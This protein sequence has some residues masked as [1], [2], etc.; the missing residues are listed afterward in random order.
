MNP[1]KNKVVAEIAIQ[2]PETYAMLRELVEK[3][4]LLHAHQERTDVALKCLA[5]DIEQLYCKGAKV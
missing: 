4:S 5:K 3:V 2:S 1:W